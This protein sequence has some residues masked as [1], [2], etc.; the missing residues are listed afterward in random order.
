MVSLEK[1]STQASSGEITNRLIS[2]FND[3]DVREVY[4]DEFINMKIATQIKVLRE[5]R[6]WTQEQ[7]AVFAEMKQERVA[8]LENVN[9]ESWTLNVLRRFAKAFDLVVDV[10]FKEFGEFLNIFDQ[11]GRE[12]LQKRPFKDDPAFKK[13]TE[14]KTFTSPK[15]ATEPVTQH[16]PLSHTLPF[17]IGLPSLAD[18]QESHQL[19]TVKQWKSAEKEDAESD[20]FKDLETVPSH[21]ATAA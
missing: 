4:S 14:N 11:F 20:L 13:Q 7:L 19:R 16:A 15:F 6:E 5:Q 1:Q 21:T 17:L 9:Y 18:A 10:E 3:P 8:V 2:D 12:S